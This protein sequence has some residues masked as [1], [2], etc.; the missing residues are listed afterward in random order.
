MDARRIFSD[1]TLN[2][3]RVERI[4]MP[5]HD[6]RLHSCMSDVKGRTTSSRAMK[7]EGA[8]LMWAS[9]NKWP[10]NVT[11]RVKIN[12]FQTLF[13]FYTRHNKYPDSHF[14]SAIKCLGL[15]VHLPTYW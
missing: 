11:I 3:R 12:L 6:Q 8:F 14:L 2:M 1:P 9:A 5:G 10:L 4:H 15:F 13:H 7:L